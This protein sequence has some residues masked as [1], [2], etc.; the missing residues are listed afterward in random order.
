MIISEQLLDSLPL[1]ELQRLDKLIITYTKNKW[2]E[3]ADKY[4][5]GNYIFKYN[6]VKLSR[7]H[8]LVMKALNKSSINYK[9]H[10][11]LNTSI[12]SRDFFY[13][14]TNR[15]IYKEH[16]LEYFNKSIEY[17]KAKKI[18]FKKPTIKI[19]EKYYDCCNKEDHTLIHTHLKTN[20]I[21]S[22]GYISINQRLIEDNGENSLL[23]IYNE[24]TNKY[25]ECNLISY[26]KSIDSYNGL[27][28]VGCSPLKV[29]N[30]LYL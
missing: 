2:A 16:N 24:K 5:L 11:F 22:H 12:Y 20:K 1:E 9:I 30:N 15:P 19:E 7:Y 18:Y 28:L 13:V 3:W 10:K 6:V 21:C 4:E 29:R 23:R 25:I 17:L 14:Y 26:F 8:E 27:E